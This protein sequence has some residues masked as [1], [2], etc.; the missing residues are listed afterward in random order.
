MRSVV[1]VLLLQINSW[2]RPEN[3]ESFV[4]TGTSGCGKQQLLKHCFQND[5]ESQ[6]AT[7]Y[8]SAQSSSSHLLQLI[9]Q[10]C[11]QASNPTGRVWRP[12]DRPNMILFLK[13]IDLPAP[14]KVDNYCL[15][16]PI[17]LSFSTELTSC[18]RFSNNFSHI[19]DSLITIW[20]GFPLKTFNLSDP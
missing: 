3:R 6:L 13:S 19:K 7:L 11:V 14:D 20:S 9:Q 5:P 2:L 4:I 15:N 10:N 17:S 8:C 12:K 1:V 18:W 16:S